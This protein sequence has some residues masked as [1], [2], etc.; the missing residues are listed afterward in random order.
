M[1][2]DDGGG[3]HFPC[4]ALMMATSPGEST[5]LSSIPLGPT[6]KGPTEL[7]KV[8]QDLL[9]QEV[10]EAGDNLQGRGWGWPS[11]L[12]GLPKLEIH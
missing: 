7:L 5:P 9:A 2:R 6:C 4:A 1:D 12:A 10:D 3:G 11:D 8:S